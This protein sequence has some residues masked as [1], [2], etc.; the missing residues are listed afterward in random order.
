MHEHDGFQYEYKH[1]SNERCK[2][3]FVYMEMTV[4]KNEESRKRE[5]DRA[6]LQRMCVSMRQRDKHTNH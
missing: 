6:L 3:C 4:K 2:H 5:G 1:E